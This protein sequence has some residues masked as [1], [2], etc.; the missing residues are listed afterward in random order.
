MKVDGKTAELV[1]PVEGEV[2]DVNR[3]LAEKPGP[4]RRGP[5]RPRLGAQGEGP[6]AR[7]QP[8]QPPLGPPR[9]QVDGGQPRGPRAAAH[10]VLRLG[11]AGRRR[12]RRRPRAT[13]SRRRTGS[14]SSTSSCSPSPRPDPRRP[15]MAFLPNPK[16]RALLFDVTRCV[17]CRE[18]AKACKDSHELPRHRRGDGARRHDLHRGPR[19]GRRPLPAPHVHAL[20]RPELRERLPGR[21]LHQDRARPGRLRRR[22]VHGLPVLHDRLPLQR[23]A[24][25]VVEADPRRP[26]VRRLLR[27]AEGRQADRVHR[28]LPGRGDGRRHPRGDAGRG[29]EAHRRE[30]RHLPPRG[31]RRERGGR[32][33]R[34]RALPRPLRAARDEDRTSATTRCRTSPGRRCRRSPRSWPAAPWASPRSTGSPTGARKSRP[35]STAEKE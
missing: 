11:A 8:P 4:R 9:P 17:G 10:G 28:G 6:P 14:A 22:Q 20:R 13:T 30:P 26:Q 15:T 34:L 24:L 2:V 35:P 18:C 12:A 19:Q 16:S 25:R 33:E 23:A 29:E 1:S 27:A 32:D 5:L 31:L 7:R 21:R 3:D